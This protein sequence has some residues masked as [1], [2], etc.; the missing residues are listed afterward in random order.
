[1]KKL[2]QIYFAPDFL[3]VFLLCVTAVLLVLGA[4]FQSIWLLCVGILVAA[5]LFFRVFSRNLPAR[6]KENQVFCHIFFAPVRALRRLGRK[7]VNRKHILSHCPSCGA[8][9][10][11]EKKTGDFTVTCPRCGTRFPMHIR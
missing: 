7:F 5:Y 9:L 4:V 11:L 8:T 2:P 3:F 10:R 1:M 6:I